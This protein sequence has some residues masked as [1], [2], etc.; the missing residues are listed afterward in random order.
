MSAWLAIC[1][2]KLAY[3]KNFQASPPGPAYFSSTRIVTLT[4][5]AA[6]SQLIIILFLR[7]LD[8]YS[9]KAS[10]SFHT[11]FI[12]PKIESGIRTSPFLKYVETIALL[13]GH[14]ERQK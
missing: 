1:A 11:V 10:Q 2:Y 3:M 4:P 9:I 14:T 6:N 12:E 5:A 7:H 8:N 13:E